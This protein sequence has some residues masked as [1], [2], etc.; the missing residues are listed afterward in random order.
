VQIELERLD[1]MESYFLGIRLPRQLENECEMWRRR[2]RAPRTVPH[3]TLIPPFQWE[4]GQEELLRLIQKHS[5]SAFQI[6]GEGLGS[7]GTAVL[8]INVTLNPALD[9]LQENLSRALQDHGIPKDKR[10]YHPHI[11]LATRLRPHQFAEYSQAL[12]DYHPQYAFKCS[13]ISLFRLEEHGAGKRWVDVKQ[14]N[15]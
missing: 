15:L 14:V 12:K 6:E 4:R 5:V 11:T 13:Q 2:F 7:F 1:R 8:F 3:I 9:T 10:P